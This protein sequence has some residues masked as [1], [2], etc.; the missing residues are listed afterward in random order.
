MQTSTG[1]SPRVRRGPRMRESLRIG[2]VGAA[3]VVIGAGCAGDDRAAGTTPTTTPE[4]T[5]TSRMQPH[6]SAVHEPVTAT[7]EVRVVR[8]GTARTAMAGLDSVHCIATAAQTGGSYSFLEI[9]IPSG[10]GPPL[11]QHTADEWFYVLGGTVVF[12]VGGRSEELRPGDYLHIPRGTQH[13]VRATSTVH[14]L[15]GYAPAGEEERL[16]CPPS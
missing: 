6:T 4:S 9:E 12:D 1:T 8:A 14:L 15:A 13:S 3:L 11:H 16:F 2:V 10:S 7:S 5:A